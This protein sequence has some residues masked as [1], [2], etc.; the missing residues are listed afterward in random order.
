MKSFR[1]QTIAAPLKRRSDVYFGSGFAFPRSNDRG[2]IEATIFKSGFAE[3]EHFFPRSNDRGSIEAFG[4]SAIVCSVI[5]FRDQ[6]IA[7]PLKQSPFFLIVQ[8]QISF[9]DQSIAAPLKHDQ[10]AIDFKDVVFFPRSNDR[11]SIEAEMCPT[12]WAW[13]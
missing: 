4:T 5:S 12:R 6:T 2:S 10:P 9:R 11:G 1:D 13:S 7:A 3:T 8:F